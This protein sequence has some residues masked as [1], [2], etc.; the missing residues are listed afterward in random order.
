[1]LELWRL[2]SRRLCRLAAGMSGGAE[3]VVKE[4]ATVGQETLGGV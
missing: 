2:R 1:M 4:A 3:E